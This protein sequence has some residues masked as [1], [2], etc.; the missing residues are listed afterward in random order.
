MDEYGY[1]YFKDRMGDTF[2]WKGENVSTMEVE[3]ILHS[4]LEYRDA[5]VYGVDVPGTE[6][7]A[8]M[9]A[10]ASDPDLDLNH[11]SK[12]LQLKLPAYAR[13]VFVRLLQKVNTT[14]MYSACTANTVQLNLW[15]IGK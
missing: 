2:R 15:H 5:V 10:I 7:R 12:Q 6:G 3:G 4:I 8:G 14:G 1:L 11:I 9:A 13:P